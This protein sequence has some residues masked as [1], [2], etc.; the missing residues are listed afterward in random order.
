MFWY[1]VTIYSLPDPKCVRLVSVRSSLPC[2]NIG[3]R[4][5]L[6]FLIYPVNRILFFGCPTYNFG[7][8]R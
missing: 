7:N 2:I 3:V 1:E 6:I 4:I 5:E 8:G